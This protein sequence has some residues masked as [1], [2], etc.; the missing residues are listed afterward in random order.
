MPRKSAS[1]SA[2]PP[3]RKVVRK[4]VVE[5]KKKRTKSKIADLTKRG[6][7]AIQLAKQRAHADD[8]AAAASGHAEPRRP[9][10]ERYVEDPLMAWGRSIIA[11][12]VLGAF[13]AELERL[14]NVEEIACGKMVWNPQRQCY[15]IKGP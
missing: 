10:D 9:P 14:K 4:S 7:D 15:V 2:A 3:R 1:S 11:P 13:N 5:K 12:E 8:A 6:N